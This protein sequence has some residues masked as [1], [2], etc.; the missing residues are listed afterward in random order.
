MEYVAIYAMVVHHQ[1]HE[2][3][4]SMDFS[5]KLESTPPLGHCP[6]GS[7]APLVVSAC[8]GFCG[9]GLTASLAI[10]ALPGFCGRSLAASF[11]LWQ[12]RYADG[13]L[14]ASLD[15]SISLLMASKVENF[16]SSS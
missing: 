4:N 16:G 2:L 10:S 9:G 6:V 13:G 3:L 14:A 8:P 7:A 11:G 5:V 1:G 12:P 15:T